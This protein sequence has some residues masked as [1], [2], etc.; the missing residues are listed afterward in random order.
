MFATP[1]GAAQTVRASREVPKR[2]QSWASM[3]SWVSRPFE[4]P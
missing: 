3:L 4:P 1:V 2:R